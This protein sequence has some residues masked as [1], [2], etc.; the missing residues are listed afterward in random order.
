IES[1]KGIEAFVNITGIQAYNHE[2]STI[3]VT[4]LSKLTYLNLANQKESESGG[5]GQREIPGNLDRAGITEID[6]SGN[7]ELMFLHVG[8]NALTSLDVSNNPKLTGVEAGNN[9]LTSFDASTLNQG[10]AYDVDEDGNI[11]Q[12]LTG[13]QRLDLK[14]N[15]LVALNL[16]N[17]L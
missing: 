5:P 12:E 2:L 8:Q 13:I 4:A 6:L 17:G 10:I 15:E 1:L 3:D 11:I 9:K 7:P 14:H 16:A